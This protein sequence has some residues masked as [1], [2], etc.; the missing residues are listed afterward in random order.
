[1]L[2]WGFADLQIGAKVVLELY[3]KFGDKWI[4]DLLLNDLIDWHA[5]LCLVFPRPYCRCL[6]CFH[7][8]RG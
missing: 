2:F 7:C 6:V 1:M 3:K 8:L 4:V 5:C